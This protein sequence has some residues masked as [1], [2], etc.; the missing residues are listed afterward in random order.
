MTWTLPLP[1]GR[2]HRHAMM[3]AVLTLLVAACQSPRSR[4]EYYGP[5][6]AANVALTT[7]DV[8]TDVPGLDIATSDTIE[9][10]VRGNPWLFKLSDDLRHE[11]LSCVFTAMVIDPLHEP[12]REVASL[13]RQE[14]EL[15]LRG[16]DQI[17]HGE[18]ER[19]AAVCPETMMAV[20]ASL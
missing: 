4:V 20:S 8:S 13:S 2:R 15:L 10:S 11:L 18:M 17:G 7:T 16:L 9:A 5:P 12:T 3:A 6:E 19:F 1:K 14:L